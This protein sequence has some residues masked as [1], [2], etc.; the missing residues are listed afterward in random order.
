MIQGGRTPHGHHRLRS[1]TRKPKRPSSKAHTRCTWAVSS[2]ITKP[3]A[4]RLLRRRIGQR[5]PAA[6]GLAF[7]LVLAQLLPDPVQTAV[8]DAVPLRQVGLG[9]FEGGDLAG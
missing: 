8:D 3:G 7:D 2:V 1:P 5:M 9:V 4:K 6:P